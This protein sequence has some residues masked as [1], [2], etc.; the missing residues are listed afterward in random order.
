MFD[1][2]FKNMEKTKEEGYLNNIPQE[3]NP[4]IMTISGLNEKI[5]IAQEAKERILEKHNLIDSELSEEVKLSLSMI[6]NKIDSYK[7]EIEDLESK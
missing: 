3:K 7:K 2:N 6:D 4:E 1:I 5:K